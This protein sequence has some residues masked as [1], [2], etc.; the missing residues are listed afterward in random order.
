MAFDFDIVAEVFPVED[1][2]VGSWVFWLCGLVFVD[3]YHGDVR[4]A[5]GLF[6]AGVRDGVFGG[7]VRSASAEDEELA[8]AFGWFREFGSEDV[9][10]E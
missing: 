5:G 1:G 6:V 8:L 10:A 2:C 3:F 7:A 4:C 9:D